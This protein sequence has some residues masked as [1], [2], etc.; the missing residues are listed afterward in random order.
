MQRVLTAMVTAGVALWAALPAAADTATPGTV[1]AQPSNAGAA[2][3]L[4]IDAKGTGA[5]FGGVFPTGVT[6]LVYKG[7]GLDLAAAGRCNDSNAS[8]GTCPTSSQIATG[9]VSGSASLAGLFAT[10]VT[11]PI[12]VFLA[13]AS[14]GDLADV[15]VEVS[16]QGTIQSA[17]GQLIGVNDPTFGYAFRFDPLPTVTAPAGTTV[18]LNEFSLDV[19]ASATGPGTTAPKPKLKPCR[20][21]YHH[22]SKN[23]CVKNKPKKKKKK[24]AKKAATTSAAVAVAAATVTHNLIT[25]PA[26]CS[27]SWPTQ[28]QVRYPDHTQT[29]DA[30]IACSP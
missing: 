22:N 28:L 26:T 25:N 2:S 15:V 12:G 7:F 24:T 6:L 19:G 10:P 16:V 3:H 29:L 9:V 30:A 1:V 20:K 13:N 4:V 27:G 23:K 14:N 5:G 18:T 8:A 17:R 21:G 11:A